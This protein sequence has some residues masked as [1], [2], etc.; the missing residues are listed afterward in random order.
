[1]VP[2]LRKIAPIGAPPLESVNVSAGSGA[3]EGFALYKASGEAIVRGRADN[4]P[5]WIRANRLRLREWLGTGIDVQWNK[6]LT[7]CKR[8]EDDVI[9]AFFADGSTERGDILIGAD[10]VSS[11]GKE[12]L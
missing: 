1:M 2:A 7:R 8:G 11:P 10:G 3:T 12:S 4:Y 5:N 6:H 9:T